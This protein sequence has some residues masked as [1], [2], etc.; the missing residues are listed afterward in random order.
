MKALVFVVLAALALS[1]CA[2][3]SADRQCKAAVKEGLLNPETL[4]WRDFRAV[5]REEF[6]ARMFALS[7]QRTGYEGEIPQSM[8][9]EH[10]A[11]FGR[12][13]DGIAEG[14]ALYG[15]RV[16]AEGRLGNTVTQEQLCI[17]NDDGCV[18]EDMSS[19]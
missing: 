14:G 9:E 19:L 18:C 10:S 2:V 12:V 17:V 11:R 6:V 8:V 15:V 3:A 7:R 1:G 13:Y 5:D 4:E 16:R